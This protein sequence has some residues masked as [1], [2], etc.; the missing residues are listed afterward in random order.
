[1]PLDGL[2]FLLADVKVGLGPA[3]SIVFKGSALLACYWSPCRFDKA[4]L[5]RRKWRQE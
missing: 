5:N 4:N 1:M 3:G 2:H